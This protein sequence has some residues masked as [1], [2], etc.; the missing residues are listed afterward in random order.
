[1]ALFPSAPGGGEQVDYGYKGK[2]VLIHLLADRNGR[3][4]LIKNTGA[5]GNEKEEALG[6][7]KRMQEYH[8][9]GNRV[10]EA[11]RGYDAYWLRKEILQMGAL[12]LIPYR[13]NIKDAPKISEVCERFNCSAVRWKVERAFAWLKRKYRRLMIRWERLAMIWK[14]FT[15]LALI[16]Y[17]LNFL[18]E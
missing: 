7:L 2:G 18:V 12:P 8:P 15:T 10:V 6:L 9:L 16:H 4:I 3:P 1:M 14:A 11:D 5:K 17:W 13:C